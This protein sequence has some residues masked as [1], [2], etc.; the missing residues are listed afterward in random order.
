MQLDV[1]WWQPAD[2]FR[3]AVR[4]GAAAPL[5]ANVSLHDVIFGRFDGGRD[6]V[7]APINVPMW[8]VQRLSLRLENDTGARRG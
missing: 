6:P 4:T 1:D 8:A 5:Q 7:L 3:D 2:P